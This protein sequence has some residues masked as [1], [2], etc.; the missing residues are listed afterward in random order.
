MTSEVDIIKTTD[1]EGN[2]LAVEGSIR[3]YAEPAIDYAKEYVRNAP[4]VVVKGQVANAAWE[5][6]DGRIR[7]RVHRNSAPSAEPADIVRGIE[8][9]LEEAWAL[10][11][12]LVTLQQQLRVIGRLHP[13]LAGPT[14]QLLSRIDRIE[15]RAEDANKEAI[16]AQE[17]ITTHEADK[18]HGGDVVKEREF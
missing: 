3:L 1:R 14:E 8:A 5:V 16:R 13:N 6:R 12:A 17:A 7:V 10:C 18:V 4:N 9:A 2:V 15:A 11:D